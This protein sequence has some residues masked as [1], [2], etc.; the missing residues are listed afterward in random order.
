MRTKDVL[1][2]IT[3]ICTLIF[4]VIIYGVTMITMVAL[5]FNQ[6]LLILVGIVGSV[7]VMG[8]KNV[9]ILYHLFKNRGKDK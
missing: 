5:G 8:H 2:L 9:M 1:S 4:K 6:I 7:W 3:E